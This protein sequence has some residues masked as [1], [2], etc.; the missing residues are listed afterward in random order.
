M[1]VTGS[2]AKTSV[3]EAIATVLASALVTLKNEGNKNNEIGLP[4]AV[5][6]APDDAE[7][8]IYEMGAGKPGDIAY[9]AAIA[10]PELHPDRHS[11]QV[12]VGGSPVEG[13][14][15]G[16]WFNQG[17]VCCAGSRLLMQESVA[18]ILIGK[19][20]NRMNTLRIGPPLDKAIDIGA[21]VAR[22]QMEPPRDPGHGDRGARAADEAEDRAD[23]DERPV[24]RAQS[25]DQRWSRGLRIGYQG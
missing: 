12:P 10:R 21:I 4:L 22:V 3:K 14:V 8:A 7:F 23:R 15:D 18:E 9:L 16:I 25:A 6:D 19:I 13:L 24:P 2:I 17:Q 1:G 11:L 5:I 20:Q